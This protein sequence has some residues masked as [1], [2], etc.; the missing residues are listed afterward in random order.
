MLVT[1]YQINLLNAQQ[2]DNVHKRYEYK[3]SFRTPKLA[4]QDG[5]VAFWEISGG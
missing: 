3:H 1:F 5:T 4:Q 2:Q